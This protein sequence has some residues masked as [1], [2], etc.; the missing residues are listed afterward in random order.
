MYKK[1]HLKC[2]FGAVLVQHLIADSLGQRH[3]SY[4][5]GLSTGQH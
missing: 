3:A 4:P 1:P 2:Y 5:P